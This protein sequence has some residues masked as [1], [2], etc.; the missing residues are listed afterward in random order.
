MLLCVCLAAGMVGFS[1]PNTE[2]IAQAKKDTKTEKKAGKIEIKEGKDGKFRFVIHD[3]DGDFLCF[4]AGFKTEKEAFEGIDDLKQVLA[5]TKPVVVKGKH[6]PADEKTDR[7][8]K[9]KSDKSDKSD[10]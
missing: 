9:K 10:K 7:K 5:S 1:L 3:E 4:S 2:A 8:D 6:D